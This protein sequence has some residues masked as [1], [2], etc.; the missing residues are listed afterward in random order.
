MVTHTGEKPF[1]CSQCEIVFSW[2]IV[3]DNH[4]LTHTE[5]WVGMEG[6]CPGLPLGRFSQEPGGRL[7]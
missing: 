3:L 7:G 4:M 2:K 5:G 6:P 1:K